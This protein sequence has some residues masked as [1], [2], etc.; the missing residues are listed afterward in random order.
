MAMSTA[1]R[2]IA[3]RPTARDRRSASCRSCRRAVE[4]HRVVIAQMTRVTQRPARAVPF[5]RIAERDAAGRAT[6]QHEHAARAVERGRPV[7]GRRCPGRAV[8]GPYRFGG[9]DAAAG[10]H[11]HTLQPLVIDE[12]VRRAHA[13]PLCVGACGLA[14]SAQC[15]KDDRASAHGASLMRRP[16]GVCQH[17][18]VALRIGANR[19]SA[20][21]R[22]AHERGRPERRARRQRVAR[23]VQVNSSFEVARAWSDR[24][25]R[26]SSQLPLAS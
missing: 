22:C 5:P 2:S 15:E 10:D 6:V 14:E 11:H 26:V 19:L 12:H 4:R 23:L 8:P 25:C 17:G 16:P 18:T 21:R 7:N 24:M 13:R 1:A 20:A 9:V 3:C